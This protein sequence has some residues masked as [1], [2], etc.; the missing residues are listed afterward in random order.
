MEP[1]MSRRF[2]DKS[3]TCK[4]RDSATD[5][6]WYRSFTNRTIIQNP[7]HSL[8]D[9]TPSLIHIL[10]TASSKGQENVTSPRLTRTDFGKLCVFIPLIL[11]G[12]LWR[13]AVALSL[14]DIRR[15]SSDDRPIVV[16][17]VVHF[18]S[19]VPPDKCHSASEQRVFK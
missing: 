9:E 7:G 6:T 14:W 12:K 17:K 5:L 10:R 15:S 3:R 11:K 4:L 13:L 19:S 2:K 18:Q 16:R 8:T 1:R